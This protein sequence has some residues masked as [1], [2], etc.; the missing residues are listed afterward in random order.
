MRAHFPVFVADKEKEG[1]SV[2]HAFHEISLESKVLLLW[3]IQLRNLCA[4]CKLEEWSPG[5][6]VEGT[7]NCLY[8]YNLSGRENWVNN[9]C[10]S[11]GCN[12]LCNVLGESCYQK[13]CLAQRSH[14][15]LYP[16]GYFFTHWPQAWPAALVLKNSL[17]SL[18]AP[19]TSSSFFL[20]VI[21]VV[22]SKDHRFLKSL[23]SRGI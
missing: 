5:S 23:P 11:Q 21:I 22:Y 2:Q 17:H 16:S 15:A 12:A 8:F 18:N 19:G 6:G 20:K 3:L 10:I 14:N 13:S 7:V 9:N 4:S 1:N